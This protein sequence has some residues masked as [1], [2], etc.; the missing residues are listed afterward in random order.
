L[1]LTL[2][3]IRLKLSVAEAAQAEAAQAEAAVV[4]AA[5][6]VEAENTEKSIILIREGLQSA[7]SLVQVELG[8]VLRQT[9]Q[10]GLIRR[11]I[12]PA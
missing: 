5:V 7:M 9:E 3:I 6:Q 2:L 8:E 4:R 10:M 1:I 12:R 11:G